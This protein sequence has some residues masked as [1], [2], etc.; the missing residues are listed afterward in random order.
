MLVIRLSRA[1]R[2]KMP[3]YHIVVA[4][5]QRAVKKQFVEE[6]G[7]YDPLFDGGKGKIVVN[8]ERCKERILQGCQPSETAARMLVKN[9]VEEA[10][11]YVPVRKTAIDKPAKKSK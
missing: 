8:V 11:K 6:L 9:G 10:S 1:G 2:K 3:F 4:E 5:K 7:Y